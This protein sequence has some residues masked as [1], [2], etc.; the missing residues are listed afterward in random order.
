MTD[1]VVPPVSHV[2]GILFDL[3]TKRTHQ[4]RVSKPVLTPLHH[5]M[6]V[7]TILVLCGG[8][9]ITI[10]GFCLSDTAN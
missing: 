1:T 9:G 6:Y 5:R 2:V 3:T 8:Q 7:G 4:Q 10:Y